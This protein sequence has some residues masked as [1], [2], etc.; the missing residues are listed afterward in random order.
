MVYVVDVPA[1]TLVWPSD[2][3]MERSAL[4][5]AAVTVRT[6]LPSL[7]W[8]ASLPLHRGNAAL[9]VREPARPDGVKVTEHFALELL[10]ATSRHVVLLN[11][12]ESRGGPCD[13]PGWRRWRS[14]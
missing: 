8:C 14:A 1:V 13:G 3:V 5:A 12:P 10:I 6:K 9:I 7:F 11:V 2:L 4:A